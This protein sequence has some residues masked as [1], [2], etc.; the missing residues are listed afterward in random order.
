MY[1]DIADDEVIG[2]AQKVTL[3]QNRKSD[4]KRSLLEIMDSE[5]A[6]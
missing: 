2:R 5:V 6:P 1:A 4:Q 3:D